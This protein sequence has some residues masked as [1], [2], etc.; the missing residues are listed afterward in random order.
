MN[1]LYLA[2]VIVG[3]AVMVLDPIFQGL[4]V[5]LIGGVFTWTAL[6]LVVVPLLHYLARKGSVP[7]YARGGF[8]E[9]RKC[10]MIRSN[11][12]GGDDAPA[13]P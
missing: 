1:F 10:V 4:A 13:P 7:G 6:A 9:L 12:R 8:R 3:A 11:G 2:A 5:V